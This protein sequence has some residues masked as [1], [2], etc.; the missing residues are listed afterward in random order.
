MHGARGRN[1]PPRRAGCCWHDGL[2]TSQS[3]PLADDADYQVVTRLRGPTA[4][5]A[6]V[7]D[8]VPQVQADRDAAQYR[9]RKRD[10]YLPGRRT[11]RGQDAET[12]GD[13][14]EVSLG[15]VRV[16]ILICPDS[17]LTHTE[18][19]RRHQWRSRRGDRGRV[20]PD[21]PGSAADHPTGDFLHALY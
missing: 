6:L 14:V 4:L 21:G 20:C 5:A 16:P 1:A 8:L 9:C 13:H 7:R 11:E 10:F 3:Q 15:F 17:H 19:P 18:D 12:A 2:A